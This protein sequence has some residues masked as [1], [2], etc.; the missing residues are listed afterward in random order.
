MTVERKY[1]STFANVKIRSLVAAEKDEYLALAA[2]SNLKSF[3]PEIDAAKNPD[4]LPI[5]F[6]A[7]VVNRVNKNGDAIFTSEAKAVCD[8]FINKQINIEH[9]RKRVIGVV[10]KAGYSEFGTDRPITEEEA[11]A[12]DGPFN[13]ALGGVI[14]RAV[15]PEVANFLEDASD[16]TSDNYDTVSASW[17]MRFNDYKVV[18]LPEGE[19]NLKAAE[20]IIE[21]KEEIDSCKAD[22]KAYGGSGVKNGKNYARALSSD[23]VSVGIGLTENPAAEVKGIFVNVLEMEDPTDEEEDNEMEDEDPSEEEKEDESNSSESNKASIN[24]ELKK[25]QEKSVIKNKVMNIKK[26][27]DLTDENLKECTA[28]TVMEVLQN[29]IKAASEKFAIEKG[30]LEKAAAEAAQNAKDL[31]DAKQKLA[32]EL[33]TVQ[34]S[35]KTLQDKEAAREA[36]EVFSQRMSSFDEKFDLSGEDRKVIASQIRELSDEDFDSYAKNMDVL[37]S[38]KVKSTKTEIEEST[39]STQDSTEDA[40]GALEKATSGKEVEG[41]ASHSVKSGE[42]SL[43]DKYKSAFSSDNIKIT[44]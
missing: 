6:N 17:E 34:A 1:K 30:E 36:Q 21:A 41:S 39:A 31:E 4:L 40:E 19:K 10:L 44:Y 13:I 43:F 5:S 18:V 9:N 35:L 26:I 24:E 2:S 12:M 42:P 27:E 14:W 28:S 8:S 29:E 11:L 20:K 7:C 23:I 33:A 22:L 32:D 37:L 38:S 16:P 25:E 3:I 15:S